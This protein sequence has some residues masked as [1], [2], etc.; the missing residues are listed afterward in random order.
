MVCCYPSRKQFGMG[1][2]MEYDT[3]IRPSIVISKE[4][5]AQSNVLHYG[6][7]SFQAITDKSFTSKHQTT[8]QRHCND[9][10]SLDKESFS[11]TDCPQLYA[12]KLCFPQQTVSTLFLYEESI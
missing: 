6:L 9:H 10:E 7:D 12:V 11:S 4:E 2:C 1:L 3:L 8:T 5:D